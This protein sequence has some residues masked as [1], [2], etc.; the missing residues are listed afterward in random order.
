MC[1]LYDALAKTKNVAALE[2]TLAQASKEVTLVKWL[3]SVVDSC[4]DEQ[5]DRFFSLLAVMR[6]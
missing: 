3:K 5:V 2:S 1:G 4:D 6:E